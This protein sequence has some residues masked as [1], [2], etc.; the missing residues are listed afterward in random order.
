MVYPSLPDKKL[1]KI[2][3]NSFHPLSI[4]TI[5]FLPRLKD[6]RYGKLFDTLRSSPKAVDNKVVSTS[7]PSM[8]RNRFKLPRDRWK[9][10]AHTVSDAR[11]FKQEVTS[12]VYDN[13]F[14]ICISAREFH[15]PVA[16]TW[17]ASVSRLERKT[18][19]S[20]L[21]FPNRKQIGNGQRDSE[22][23]D[24]FME[25]ADTNITQSRGAILQREFPDDNKS[26]AAI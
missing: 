3:R 14:K 26:R 18:G 10:M 22:K 24:K 8:L 6:I 23:S 16:R 12:R 5:R 15:D 13:A 1:K 9:R 7:I 2:H 11:H 4:P 17:N 21:P 25:N 20:I 19:I